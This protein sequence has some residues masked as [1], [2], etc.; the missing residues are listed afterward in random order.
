[1]SNPTERIKEALNEL[2]EYNDRTKGKISG[3]MYLG[4]DIFVVRLREQ[5]II[6]G[7]WEEIDNTIDIMEL[8]RQSENK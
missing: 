4:K 6:D 1:M 2:C 7:E 8:I 5:K 3:E